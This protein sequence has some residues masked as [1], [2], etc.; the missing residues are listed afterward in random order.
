MKLGEYFLYAENRDKKF[1]RK[2]FEFGCDAPVLSSK[3]L[4]YLKTAKEG[5]FKEFSPQEFS[6]LLTSAVP[7]YADKSN[8]IFKA[9]DTDNSGDIDMEEFFIALI[10]GP[11]IDGK[12][13][14]VKWTTLEVKLTLNQFLCKNPEIMILA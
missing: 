13:H 7:E 3:L 2:L 11:L 12:Y 8:E 1:R 9:I 5:A 4:D 6:T 14:H 10:S